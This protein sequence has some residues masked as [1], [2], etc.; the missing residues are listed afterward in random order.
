MHREKRIYSFD[1]I[2]FAA[3]VCVIF[4]HYQAVLNVQFAHI[5]FYNGRF[6]FGHLVELFF[7][8]SGF[9]AYSNIPQIGETENFDDF[10]KKRCIRLLPMN[11]LAAAVHLIVI[12]LM[13]GG[14]H[15]WGWV[16]SSS[17]LYAVDNSF[18]SYGVN[19]PCW[20]VGVLLIC[21]IWF[22]AITY[23][24]KKRQ[25]PRTRL[26]GAMV[27]LGLLTQ[28]L[29]WDAPFFNSYTGR[30][31]FAFFTGLLVREL[32]EHHGKSR[33]LQLC[34]AGVL[35]SFGLIFAFYPSLISEGTGYLLTLFVYPSL[36]VLCTTARCRKLFSFRWL[37]VLGEVSFGMY[38]FHTPMLYFL[39]HLDSRS[40]PELP[41]GS[42]VFMLLITAMI[43]AVSFASLYLIEKPVTR[44]LS[45]RGKKIQ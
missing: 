35:I 28:Q 17:G 45:A 11:A 2:K 27:L 44:R 15:I 18:M 25:L 12:W 30:G 19:P 4:H 39:W 31:Y 7:I 14:F 40:S 5:N 34:A 3:A 6:Y 1:L 43:I 9:L 10:F 23:W 29:A 36:V 13:Y 20:Y 26:Y 22:Y 8:I 21:N 41:L 33:Q 42:P 16:I 24:A 32:T 37:S 38:L